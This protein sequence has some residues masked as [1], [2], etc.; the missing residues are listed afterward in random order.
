MT[1][2]ASRLDMSNIIEGV[3]VPGFAPSSHV[4]ACLAN[5][6]TFV[7]SEDLQVPKLDPCQNIWQ[8]ESHWEPNFKSKE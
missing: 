1:S 3:G 6:K 8:L 7:V 2:L 4:H 5:L